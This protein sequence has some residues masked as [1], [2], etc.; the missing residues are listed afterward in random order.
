[1]GRPRHERR[2]RAAAPT[3]A[4]E[5][6]RS[7]DALRGV[8]ILGI[9]LV[10]VQSFAMIEAAYLNPTAYGDLSG[11]NGWCWLAVHLFADRKHLPIFAALLAAGIL[12]MERRSAAAGFAR[13]HYRR[14]GWLA[15]FGLVHA[16]LLWSGDILL[17]LAL[18]GALVF[19]LRGGAPRWLAGG[20]LLVLAAS[21]LLPLIAGLSVS[22]WSPEARLEQELEWRPDARRVEQETAFHLA[23]WREQVAGRVGSVS[24]RSVIFLLGSAWQIAGYMLIGMA[25]FKWGFLTGER[26]P[27]CYRNAL[28]AG[29]GIGLPIVAVGTWLSFRTHWQLDFAMFHGSQLNAWG[30][31]LMALGYVAAML[32]GDR[33][34]RLSGLYNRLAAV[35]RMA[36]SNYLAQSL[37]CSTLF[38]GHGL[39]LFGRLDRGQQLLVVLAV[40]AVSLVVSPL[41]LRR[42]AFGPAEW[43]WR[44]LSY[45]KLQPQRRQRPRSGPRGLAGRL[46]GG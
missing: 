45:R 15:V 5:R 12:Q 14:M 2:T 13:L 46:A 24:V 18:S 9:L 42:F 8:S 30:S 3:A 41:W 29:L 6:L 31:L 43:L 20:G 22:Y 34:Q 23:S 36:L 7:L 25:L 33:V 35:G 16:A 11:V 27:R 19:P 39:A 32:L 26:L 44:S 1:M 40:W 4:G 38:Y 17:A 37:I 28:A 10:N 21:S